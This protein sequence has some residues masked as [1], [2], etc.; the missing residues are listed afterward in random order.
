[1][2][3]DP[4]A[5]L[6]ARLLNAMKRL[7]LEN[8]QLQRQL[9]SLQSDF[10]QASAEATDQAFRNRELE[11]EL[12]TAQQQASRVP[13][14]EKRVEAMEL[15]QE[16]WEVQ[17][18]AM[19][20]L[21][22]RQGMDLQELRNLLRERDE[23]IESLRL[24]TRARTHE[25]ENVKS[26]ARQVIVQHYQAMKTAQEQAQAAIEE[27]RKTR[28]RLDAIRP[29]VTA[30][31]RKVLPPRSLRPVGLAPASHPSPQGQN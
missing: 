26:Q 24:L 8:I 22:Q 5:P 18:E 15:A 27:A 13:D 9:R 4:T 17:R 1:M 20:R 10:A 31:R 28:S 14:L 29:P 6:D 11:M 30:G 25:L 21:A 12:Q 3:T 7:R 2:N 23:E 16:Q 19:T